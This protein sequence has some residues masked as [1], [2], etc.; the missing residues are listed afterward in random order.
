[1][2]LPIKWLLLFLSCVLLSG[3]VYATEQKAPVFPKKKIAINKIV[4]EVEVA[5]TVEQ[6][7]YGLMNRT[8]LLDN[9]GMMF[10]FMWAERQ[11]QF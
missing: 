9:Q 8:Q 4:L 7:S 10:V 6:Q 1:M 3:H 2:A 5:E 11:R